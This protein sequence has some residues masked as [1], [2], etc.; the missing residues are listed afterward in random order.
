MIYQK[1]LTRPDGKFFVG[2][3]HSNELWRNLAVLGNT[4]RP[5]NSLSDEPEKHGASTRNLALLRTSKAIHAEAG[6]IIYGQEL[7]FTDL[8]DLQNFLAGLR[9]LHISLL[10]HVVLAPVN[11]LRR[12]IMRPLMPSVFSLLAGA[13]SLETLDPDIEVI[14]HA[15]IRLENSM[16]P[17]DAISTA[18]WDSVVGRAIAAEVYCHLFTYLRRAVA[19]RGIDKVLDVLHVFPMIFLHGPDHRRAPCQPRNILGVEWTQDRKAVMKKAMG[20][21]I[22]RLLEKDNN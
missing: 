6:A 1:A 22:E 3:K 14:G 4:P 7:V 9:P 17:C 11:S 16:I 10:R 20:E 18:A 8:V 13:D 2:T 12:H 15:A 5:S 21:E 19:V